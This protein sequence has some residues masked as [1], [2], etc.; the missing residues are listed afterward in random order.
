MLAHH[1]ETG[2]PIR[3]LQS[4]AQISQDNKTLAWIQPTFAPSSRWSRWS[5]LVSD[6]AALSVLTDQGEPTCCVVMTTDPAWIPIVKRTVSESQTVVVA[7]RAVISWLNAHGVDTGHVLGIYELFDLY[8]YLGEPVRDHDPVEKVVVSMAHVLR[9]SRIVWTATENVLDTFGMRAQLT[10]W[11]RHME[12]VGGGI[13]LQIPANASDTV[14]PECWLI[15]QYFKHPLPRRSREIWQTLERNIRNPYIDRI[16]LLNETADLDLPKS[17]KLVVKV[18]PNRLTYADVLRAIQTELPEGAIAVFSNSDIWFDETLKFLWCLRMEE[19]RLFLALLRWEEREGEAPTLF[20][21]RADSQD[22][23]IVA[24]RTVD[25]EVKDEDFGFPFGKPGCDNAMTVAMLRRKCLI[26]N[27]AYTIYTHHQHASNIRNYNPRDCL[28]K[29]AYLYVDPTVIHPIAIDN[30]EA[31]WI[32]KELGTA[33]KA[34][35]PTASFTRKLHPVHDAAGRTLCTMLNR[36]DVGAAWSVDGANRWTPDPAPQ[37]L[38]EWKG[39]MFVTPD[40]LI[41][42]PTKVVVGR[43]RSWREGWEKASVSSMTP[44]LHI[45]AMI[46][47]THSATNW[48]SLSNWVLTQLPTVLRVRDVLHT[49]E[50]GMRPEF[51]VPSLDTVAPFLYDCAWNE[52]HVGTFPY[53]TDTQYY[54]DHLLSVAPAAAVQRVTRED[55]VRLRR[56]LPRPPVQTSGEGAPMLVLCVSDRDGAVCTPGWAEELQACHGEQVL[57]GWTVR[58]I[59]ETDSPKQRREAFQ[60][61]AWIV[62][63]RGAL[64]WLWM[65]RPETRI[66]ECMQENAIADDILHLAGAAGCFYVPLLIPSKEPVEFQRERALVDV[67]RAMKMFGFQTLLEAKFPH[68]EDLPLVVVP[69]D[70]QGTMWAHSGDS[71]R[72]MV[73]VWVSR[74]YCRR[75]YS[76]ETGL[77]WWGGVGDT[78]LFDWDTPRWW[79]TQMPN[80]RFALFGNAAPPGPSGHE[81]R[82]SVWSMWP[83]HPKLLEAF[84]A[85]HGVQTWS[86]RTV[87]SLFLGKVENGV[88]KEHRC[89]EDWSTAVE[90][91]SMPM[92]STGGPYPY[93]PQEY[94]EHVAKSRFGLCLR[95]Y[96]PKCNREIEYMAVGTVPVVTE[97]VDMTHFLSP[98]REG[99]HFLRAKTPADVQRVIAKTTQSEWERMSAACHAWWRENASAEGLFRLTWA[100]IEQC[101]PYL[102]AGILPA[103]APWKPTHH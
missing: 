29:P 70:Q 7:T 44:A 28:Y 90:M 61:A 77:C 25:F 95:G 68:E 93:T 76:T 55:V 24:K 37:P 97:G 58:V 3:I 59:R 33:W 23:W 41:S 10:A 92:D 88:Q 43:H 36:R 54:T 56:L 69:T 64:E 53:M 82:Q 52:S 21:P 74:G 66:V 6:P 49:K 1:P 91:F 8:P 42:S 13:L 12:S 2:Q 18:Q 32:C 84:V 48:G 85:E 75:E 35:V 39:G 99:V 103:W 60:R 45:P 71:F 102:T 20:G 86:D 79:N 63:E 11:R 47:L 31:G 101:R 17:E 65:A 89:G 40:G 72:E 98:P 94:L 30:G 16:L 78:V 96:G 67:G 26:V 62:G 9:H 51:I 87:T 19:Q 38:Y 83:R 14:V 46:S 15:Q 50:G 5:T 81:A 27:P 22:S 4:D 73:D 57:K 80:Y 100:R 34:T